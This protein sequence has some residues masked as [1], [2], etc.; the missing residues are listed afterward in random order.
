[1]P[2]T[3]P[4][5]LVPLS[6]AG[7]ATAPDNAPSLLPR[8]IERRSDAEPV[9]PAPVATPDATLDAEIARRGAAVDAAAA[10]FDA[11]VAATRPRLARGR[12]ATEGSDAWIDAQAALGELDQA[13]SNL[14]AALG[15]LEQ[16]A[17]ARA[18][19]LAAPYPALEA[20]IAAAQ[21]TLDRARAA[22]AALKRV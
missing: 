16:L 1:M 18:A 10:A 17:A 13:S 7:C 21:T 20:R 14:D 11:A 4:L 5:L 6:L 19:R 8:A 22:L 2:R 15:D 3:V 9:R 12:G